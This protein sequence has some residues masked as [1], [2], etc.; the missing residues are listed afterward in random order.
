MS[1]FP[2]YRPSADTFT[3]HLARTRRIGLIPLFLSLLLIF[4]M[5]AG[6]GPG[7]WSALGTALGLHLLLFGASRLPSVASPAPSG[8]ADSWFPP[9]LYAVQTGFLAVT[10]VL[11]WRT[12]RDLGHPSSLAEEVIFYILLV[13]FPVHRLIRSTAPYE[14]MSPKQVRRELFLR[15]FK[16]SLTVIL[17]SLIL[18]DLMRDPGGRINQAGLIRA[19]GL[20]VVTV[21]FVLG[22]VTFFVERAFFSAPG[23]QPGRSETAPPGAS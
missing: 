12:L 1:I 8:S 20:W 3:D 19:I 14:E 10:A 15:Y 5:P 13:C 23:P 18:T 22:C 11:L 6:P 4:S 7:L 9:L 2:E 17:F 16:R 21:L